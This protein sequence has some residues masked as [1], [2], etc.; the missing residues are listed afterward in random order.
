[1]NAK[2]HPSEHEAKA[3]LRHAMRERLR[4]MDHANAAASSLSICNH[5]GQRLA[6]TDGPVL[7]FAPIRRVSAGI[8]RPEEVDLGDLHHALVA[9]GRL[10]L[11]R[12]DW[13]NRAMR[14]WLLPRAERLDGSRDLETR[15]FDVPEPALG[16][17]LDL[18]QLDAV[19]VPGLAFDRSGARLGRG[20]GFYDRFLEPLDGIERAPRL[21]GVCFERQLAER[22]PVEEHDRRV[23]ALVT[24]SGV[25]VCNATGA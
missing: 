12:I 22:V 6:D 11:P 2:Q 4:S 18:Q 21:I 23:G 25:I 15:R 7:S 5:L 20:A 9:Q 8:D 13:D 10:A 3:D 16:E 1:M 19:L 14:A 24:E 17:P